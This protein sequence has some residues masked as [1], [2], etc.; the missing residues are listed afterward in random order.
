MHQRVNRALA[1]ALATL[2]SRAASSHGAPWQGRLR[3]AGIST[4][5][6]NSQLL[7]GRSS[8]RGAT[9]SSVRIRRRRDPFPLLNQD[10][11]L[12]E[13]SRATVVALHGLSKLELR[14][15]AVRQLSRL[16]R[17]TTAGQA[18]A[19]EAALH[20][21]LREAAGDDASSLREVAAEALWEAWNWYPGGGD[22]EELMRLGSALFEKQHYEQAAAAFTDA[23][24]RAP[25][26]AGGWHQRALTHL[27]M[28]RLKSCASDCLKVL[29]L[30]PHHYGSLATLGMCYQSQGLLHAA[31]DCFRQCLDVHPGLEHVQQ[32][33]K[34]SELQMVRT[35]ISKRLWPRI[36]EAVQALSSSA[37]S[38]QWDGTSE[39][40]ASEE[41]DARLPWLDCDWDVVR[42]CNGSSSDVASECNDPD[43]HESKSL[44]Q[45][46]FR[47]RIQR[48]AGL[49]MPG[50]ARVRSLARFYILRFADGDVFPLTR[51]TNGPR[52]FELGPGDRYRFTFRLWSTQELADASG[53]MILDE[54]GDVDANGAATAS[55]C[56]GSSWKPSLATVVPRDASPD[57]VERLRLG[58]VDV[59]QLDLRQLK[60]GS[61]GKGM[62]L[63]G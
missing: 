55:R 9:A 29:Q 16:A 57:E 7:P 61:V 2:R 53:G 62:P 15:V 20:R 35:V 19:A 8:P 5:A 42:V 23:T 49:P 58:Y 28:R 31:A 3:A 14:L 41:K 39:L 32:A 26:F 50:P 34:K 6:L 40:G 47:V 22:V 37:V 36:A 27:A 44:Q 10:A 4:Q 51:L 11:A 48:N 46:V 17:D 25:T 60:L 59:G 33:M 52:I 12:S 38:A 18:S 43:S 13:V 45:Y 54:E 30:K 24:A 56:T 1:E 21:V 63:G